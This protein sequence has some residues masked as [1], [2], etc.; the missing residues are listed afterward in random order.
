MLIVND[1]EQ[2]SPE[3]LLEKLGKPSASNCSKIVTSAGKPS[4]QRQGYLYELASERVTGMVA[5]G[6]KNAYMQEGN[7]REQEARSFFEMVNDVTVEKVGV[8]YKDDKKRFLCSPDGIVDKKEGLELKNPLPKTQVG[9][10]LGG[11]L[12]TDYFGQ[13]QFSLYVTGFDVWHFVSYVPAMNPLIIKVDRDEK[14][15]KALEDELEKFCDE[16]DEI[17]EKIKRKWS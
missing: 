2:G 16:L 9:Y 7:D 12:P 15:I 5:D 6:F 11:G 3:W 14:F 1:F 10:L 8:I 4:K 13:V 17:T